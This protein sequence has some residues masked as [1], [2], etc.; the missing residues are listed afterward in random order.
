MAANVTGA[1][2]KVGTSIL[3]ARWD[4][5]PTTASGVGL[6]RYDGLL[7]DYARPSLRGRIAQID[8]QLRAL[9][10]LEAKGLP[11]GRARLGS[12]PHR[13][14]PGGVQRTWTPKAPGGCLDQPS[15]SPRNPQC[16]SGAFSK[17]KS[18][19]EGRGSPEVAFP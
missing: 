14:S 19:K 5:H 9:H 11:T 7:G 2:A 3:Q 1:V 4:F 10:A 17:T 13:A 18:R 8:K 12:G 6:H 16:I 15:G